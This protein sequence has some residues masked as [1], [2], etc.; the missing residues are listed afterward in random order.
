MFAAVQ[1]GF[2][3]KRR[4]Y[5]IV[6]VEHEHTS[7][8]KQQKCFKNYIKISEDSKLKKKKYRFYQSQ[9]QLIIIRNLIQFENTNINKEF[10]GNV[11]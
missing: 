9:H 5:C 10:S 6:A 8:A 4:D 11:K 3:A 7:C 1:T 2:A